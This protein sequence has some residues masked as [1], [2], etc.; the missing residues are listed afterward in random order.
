MKNGIKTKILTVM[1]IDLAGY[2]KTTSKLNVEE[3]DQLHEIFDNLTLPIFK[4]YS[5]NIIK[6]IG[7]AFLATFESPTSA[8]L[9]GVELQKVFMSYTKSNGNKPLHI[10]VAIHTGEVLIRKKDVYGDT[11]NIAARIESVAKPDHVVFSEAVLNTMNKNELPVMFA[12][13]HKLKGLKKPVK[14]F[15]VERKIDKI[16]RKKRI[17]QERADAIKRQFG[18]ASTKFFVIVVI[19]VVVYILLHFV[20]R[21]I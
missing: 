7:D 20:F 3:F 14:L 5:G 18:F 19:L 13:E 2:T 6:K 10:R 1:F 16:I 9:C 12:G 15:R 4:N 11:V 17:Q 8:V 21:V